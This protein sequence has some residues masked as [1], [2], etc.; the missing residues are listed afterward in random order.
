MVIFY[1]M[2]SWH[3][4]KSRW[5]DETRSTIDHSVSGIFLTFLTFQIALESFYELQ[6]YAE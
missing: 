5:K 3:V 1:P 6:L 4:L 2:Q